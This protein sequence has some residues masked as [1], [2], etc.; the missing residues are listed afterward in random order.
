M[1][2]RDCAQTTHTRKPILRTYVCGQLNSLHTYVHKEKKVFSSGGEEKKYF[3]GLSSAQLI[4]IKTISDVLA[5]SSCFSVLDDDDQEKKR[6]PKKNSALDFDASCL[7]AIQCHR[8]M[9]AN[10]R[11]G[12]TLQT[13]RNLHHFAGKSCIR[14]P[15]RSQ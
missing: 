4:S 3:V 10:R 14:L 8:E 12:E 6:K 7:Q 5:S 13:F 1:Q 15:C 9:A 2:K 11:M